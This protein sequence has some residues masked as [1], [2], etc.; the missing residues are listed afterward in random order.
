MVGYQFT[1]PSRRRYK[2]I[3]FQTY[4]KGPLGI[5]NVIG[6]QN[7]KI[8]PLASGA[9][10]VDC[11]DHF[12]SWP[13]DDP[14]YVVWRTAGGSATNNRSGRTVR[15]MAQMGIATAYVYKSA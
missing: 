3:A 5:G 15:G 12:Q 8:C 2:S 10:N 1:L 4:G 7:F 11:F 14:R 13:G 6:L 9:W